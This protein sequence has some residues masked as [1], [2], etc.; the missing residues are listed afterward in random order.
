MILYTKIKL[1]IKIVYVVSKTCIK[2]IGTKNIYLHTTMSLQKVP[3][4]DLNE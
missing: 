3:M 2:S 4:A 1:K